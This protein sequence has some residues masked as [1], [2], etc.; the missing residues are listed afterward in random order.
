MKGLSLLADTGREDWSWSSIW[1][2]MIPGAAKSERVW[3]IGL[4]VDETLSELEIP[5]IWGAVNGDEDPPLRPGI[6]IEPGWELDTPPFPLPTW[7]VC[8]CCTKKWE[9][10]T[11]DGDL[12]LAVDDKV[13]VGGW[14]KGSTTPGSTMSMSFVL[15][16]LRRRKKKQPN[17]ARRRSANPPTTPPMMGPRWLELR[18]DFP[19]G[20][21]V[22][23]EI[24]DVRSPE[25]LVSVVEVPEIWLPEM[26]G[27]AEFEEV[28][29]SPAFW[30]RRTFRVSGV[31]CEFP[32]YT[33]SSLCEPEESGGV[34]NIIWF[35]SW[36]VGLTALVVPPRRLNEMGVC[37]SME[38]VAVVER[39]AWLL[40]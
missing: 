39:S 1:G 22:A 18:A 33:M 2:R 5:C 28:E 31:L 34:W 21:V 8:W 29:D 40:A 30:T 23:T 17:I 11:D 15:S 10:S 4:S 38:Y 36:P 27:R 24:G 19:E 7:P 37:P 12:P 35:K 16:I 13:A 25:A 32:W 9:D 14:L 3:T 6:G 26:E 20:N